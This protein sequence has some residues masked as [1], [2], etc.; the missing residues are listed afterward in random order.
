MVF[1]P[2]LAVFNDMTIL[3]YAEL[4]SREIIL[5]GSSRIPGIGVEFVVCK[6][7][8]YYLIS[9]RDR[10]TKNRA[11]ITFDAA[12]ET[13]LDCAFDSLVAEMDRVLSRRSYLLSWTQALSWSGNPRSC[14]L[15]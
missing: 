13:P 1:Q 11:A 12:K 8:L 9:D 5:Q 2:K 15:V 4:S 7:V 10:R 6:F 3:W 14:N